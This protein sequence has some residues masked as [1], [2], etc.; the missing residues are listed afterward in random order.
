[1]LSIGMMPGM[2]QM[3]GM[4]PM[5]MMPGMPQMPGMPPT[6]MMPHMPGQQ[7]APGTPGAM[8]NQQGIMDPKQYEQFYQQWT[9]MMSTMN[10]QAK[11][12]AADNQ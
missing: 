6:G 2:P 11:P 9:E 7:G 10:P 5:G 8:P 12:E 1:M 4:P 3:P